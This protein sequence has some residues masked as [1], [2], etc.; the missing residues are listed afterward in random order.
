MASVRLQGLR[1]RFGTHDV[2]PSLDLEINDHEFM[3]FV[4]PRAAA[5]PRCCA[6]SPGWSRSPRAICSSASA[7]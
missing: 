3:V 5:N 4:G 7:G 6:S 1:K 2:I